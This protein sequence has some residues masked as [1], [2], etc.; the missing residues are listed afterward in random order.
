MFAY[1]PYL[2]ALQVLTVADRTLLEQVAP[3]PATE[4]LPY[5]P[6]VMEPT[7]Q[8]ALGALLRLH[9]NS[10]LSMPSEAHMLAVHSPLFWALWLC[11]VLF[12]SLAW[13]VQ[14]LL[15]VMRSHLTQMRFRPL[16]SGSGLRGMKRALSNRRRLWSERHFPSTAE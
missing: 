16:A 10:C 12:G 15:E 1:L 8:A 14:T 11:I 5:P 6:P 4:L 9:H 2:G 7:L 13:K 3:L